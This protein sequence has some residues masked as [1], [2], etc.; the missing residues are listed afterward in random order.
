MKFTSLQ[1]SASFFEDEWHL[2]AWI[3]V[4]SDKIL[5]NQFRILEIRGIVVIC[6]SVNFHKSFSEIFEPPN[7]LFDV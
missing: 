3:T 6:G 5:K 7:E 1:E 4:S 2:L